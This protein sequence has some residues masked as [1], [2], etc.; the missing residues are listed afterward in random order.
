MLKMCFPLIPQ[1]EKKK[2]RG[3]LFQVR[4]MMTSESNTKSYQNVYTGRFSNPIWNVSP[5]DVILGLAQYSMNR[6]VKC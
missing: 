5:M 2:K 4:V 3:Y 1:Q 6:D